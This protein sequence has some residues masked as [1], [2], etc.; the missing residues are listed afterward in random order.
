MKEMHFAFNFQHFFFFFLVRITKAL[1]F[2]KYTAIEYG[3]KFI[4]MLHLIRH[5]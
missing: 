2:L 3:K 5:K 4:V 1:L